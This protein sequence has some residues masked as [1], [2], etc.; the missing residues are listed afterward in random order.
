M[1]EYL[2]I[3]GPLHGKSQSIDEHARD[4]RIP[5]ER[6][7][8]ASVSPQAASW[9]GPKHETYT[10]KHVDIHER[11]SMNRDGAL[12]TVNI[13]VQVRVLAHE[14]VL[15][16]EELAAWY[17]KL[18]HRGADLHGLLLGMDLVQR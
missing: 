6:C 12:Y 8:L 1:R 17:R 3:G 13:S 4:L 5:S 14:S 10:V 11:E 7:Y 16:M 2:C 18:R 9:D 15:T